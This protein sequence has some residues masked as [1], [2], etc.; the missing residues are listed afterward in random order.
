MIKISFTKV[1][2]Y[3]SCDDDKVDVSYIIY[4]LVLFRTPS[5][6]FLVIVFLL[7]LKENN[8][9]DHFRLSRE[10]RKDMGRCLVLYVKPLT[11]SLRLWVRWRLWFSPL[12]QEIPEIPVLRWHTV[13]AYKIQVYCNA[14]DA[15][16]ICRIPRFK[17]IFRFRE[18]N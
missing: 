18:K 11:K 9:Y 1:D 10:S 15:K 12:D 3:G 14:L 7:E 5:L 6:C 17:K 4:Y 16:S 8:F 2:L 13:L